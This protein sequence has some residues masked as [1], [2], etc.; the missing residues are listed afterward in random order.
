M[1]KYFTY[2]GTNI[3]AGDTVRVSQ[4]IQEGDKTRT[5]IYEGVVIS[6]ANRESGKSF[7]VRK[8]AA[9]GVGVERIFPVNS[10]MIEKIELKQAGI[11]KRAKLF[12]LRDRIGKAASA[13]RKRV[14]KETTQK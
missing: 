3:S 10:P 8:I 5:Q 12:Y 6:V 13:I 14:D 7:T 4:R 9:G 11:V 1:S 2:N